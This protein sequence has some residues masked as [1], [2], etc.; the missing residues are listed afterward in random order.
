M[1]KKARKK[2]IIGGVVAA[3]IIV[4]IAY[5]V[6]GKA[7]PVQMAEAEHG[8]I[9]AYVE[10]RAITTLPHT[11]RLTMPHSGRIEPILLEEGTSVKKGEVVARMDVADLLTTVKESNDIITAMDNAVKASTQMVLASQAQEKYAQFVW[12][13]QQDLYKR[14][15]ISKNAMKAAEKDFI[16][17]RVD[18]RSDRFVEQAMI[19]LDAAVN[20]M[21]VYLNRRLNRA[22]LISPIDGLILKRHVS[23]ELVLQAGNALLDIG[24]MGK[25]E[26]TSNILSDEAVNIREGN[27]VNIYGPSIGTKPIKGTVQ[28]VDPKGF[29]KVSSLGVEQQ[30]VAVKI[31]LYK[32]DLKML[33]ERGKSLGVDYRVHVRIFTESKDNVVKIPRTALFRGSGGDWEAFVVENGKAKRVQIQVGITNDKEAEITK[34]IASGDTVVVAPESSLTNGTKVKKG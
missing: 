23:N 18:N 29:T 16:K 4:V 1:E 27:P 24:D 31:T 9:R 13:A 34:G 21:P 19:A 11:Y 28:R 17:S 10:E 8:R 32:G 2:W 6:M 30:R 7:I 14:K 12:K 20:L 33:K 22:E 5:S 26:V 15:Q 3:I 25:L